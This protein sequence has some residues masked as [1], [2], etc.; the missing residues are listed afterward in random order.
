MP[1]LSFYIIK[2]V[3]DPVRRE[4]RNLGILTW[5]PR[6][7]GLRF[8]GASAE[9][10]RRI[11]GRRIAGGGLVSL[12]T[13]KQWVTALSDLANSDSIRDL[14][15]G[16]V[17]EK[18]SEGFVNAMRSWCNDAIIIADGGEVFLESI[19]EPLE[20]ILDS[21]FSTYIQAITPRGE[22]VR[23]AIMRRSD[24]TEVQAALRDLIE[25]T[26]LKEDPY[27]VQKKTLK[28]KV[29][30]GIEEEVEF[31]YAYENGALHRLI[32]TVELPHRKDAI[33]KNIQSTAWMFDQV[34]NNG[35]VKENQVIAAVCIPESRMEEPE[36]EHGVALIGSMATIWNLADV[37][38]VSKE[39]HRLPS[40]SLH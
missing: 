33:R 21:L 25:S 3:P 24:A 18:S 10:R 19:D 12:H 17:V 2:F 31:S 9:S 11:D 35:I 37:E 8:A 20:P 36:V 23:E 32:Q 1:S 7:V 30:G 27:L 13:Y 29:R 28:C 16:S 22:L 14:N 5:S 39:L 4:P 38:S 15:S 6:G 34:L 26:S 40:L